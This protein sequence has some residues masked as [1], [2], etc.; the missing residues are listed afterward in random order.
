MASSGMIKFTVVLTCLAVIASHAEALSCPGVLNT[1]APC[2]AFLRGGGAGPIP[3]ACCA[4]VRSL[5]MQARTTPDRQTACRCLKA[6]INS[7]PN[8]NVVSGIAPKCGVNLSFKVTPTIDC[9][10]YVSL[11]IP[12]SSGSY[13]F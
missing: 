11:C 10:T 9:A 4:G 2:V 3:A 6:V 12:L 5:N 8:P 13:I 7:I 1:V